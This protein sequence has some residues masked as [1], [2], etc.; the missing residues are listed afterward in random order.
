VLLAFGL[1]A[2][3]AAR[4]G[5]SHYVTSRSQAAGVEAQLELLSLVGALAAPQDQTPKDMPARRGP[6]SGAM[7]SGNPAVPLAPV[8]TEV[9]RSGQWAICE[10]PIEPAGPGS[11]AARWEDA[12]FSPAPISCSIF[13]PPRSR[14]HFPV[15]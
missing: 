14:E 10:L 9:Q 3:Q 13:H 7:C 1:F 8:S 12:H 5:C 6:C 2:P 4:A 15:S 11:V